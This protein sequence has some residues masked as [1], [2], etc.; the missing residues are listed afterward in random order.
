M[1]SLSWNSVIIRDE[2][3]IGKL[4]FTLLLLNVVDMLATV[5]GVEIGLF[6]E[7]NPLLRWCLQQG[8]LFFAVVKMTLCVQFILV[9]MLLSRKVNHLALLTC[10]IVVI[11]SAVVIRSFGLLL[12]G[13][14]FFF[15]Y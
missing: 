8:I 1:F 3:L 7:A 10:I 13:E 5:W 9:V 14:T 4:L 15:S 12:T 6:I 11:Y 2:L